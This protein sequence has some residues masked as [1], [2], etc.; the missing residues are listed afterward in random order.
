MFLP[1]ESAD[2]KSWP[3]QLHP[4]TL[5]EHK[6]IAKGGSLKFFNYTFQMPAC[7]PTFEFYVDRAVSRVIFTW[8]VISVWRP[9][10]EFEPMH[11]KA[12]AERWKTSYASLLWNMFCVSEIILYSAFQF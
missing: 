4:S 10:F 1:E 2:T 7:P 5:R 11:G 6:I 9:P 8:K 12:Y 3:D